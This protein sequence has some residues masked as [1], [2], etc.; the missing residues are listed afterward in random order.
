QHAG[1]RQQP[2]YDEC[3]TR[4]RAADVMRAVWAR[5]ARTATQTLPAHIRAKGNGLAA[6]RW[7]AI[8]SASDVT[9]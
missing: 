3:S 5:C 7:Q 6:S 2:H 9:T 8:R 1:E 4:G